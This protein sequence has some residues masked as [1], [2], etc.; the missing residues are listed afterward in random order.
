VVNDSNNIS[1]TKSISVTKPQ[2]FTFGFVRSWTPDHSKKRRPVCGTCK[3]FRA[4]NLCLY[5]WLWFW[6]TGYWITELL[7]TC[8]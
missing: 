1:D 2:S 8:I 6:C 3:S 4:G 7:D 5:L